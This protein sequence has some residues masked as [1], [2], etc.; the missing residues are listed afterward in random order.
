MWRCCAVLGCAVEQPQHLTAPAPAPAP[1]PPHMAPTSS[2]GN[3]CL[4]D[5]EIQG[6]L[7]FNKRGEP[8]TTLATAPR[9]QERARSLRRASGEE[10]KYYT[11]RE[12]CS[13]KGAVCVCVCMYVC[14]SV[15]VRVCFI[16]LHRSSVQ[17]NSDDS[18]T[19][20]YCI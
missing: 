19:S 18:G 16:R 4:A 13:S 1:A 11:R 6:Q 3:Y 15:C 9:P 20:M 5:P 12:R 7:C 2:Q 8:S 14:V 10:I 17:L